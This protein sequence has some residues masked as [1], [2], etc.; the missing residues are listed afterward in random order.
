MVNIRP[1]AAHDRLPFRPNVLPPRLVKIGFRVSLAALS[2]FTL[3]KANPIVG[4]GITSAVSMPAAALA[5]AGNSVISLIQNGPTADSV[6]CT[7][8]G[9]LFSWISLTGDFYF[10]FAD[11]RGF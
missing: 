5:F 8:A 1:R 4:Y 10:G 3:S 6:F 9:A 7:A 2:C 11:R